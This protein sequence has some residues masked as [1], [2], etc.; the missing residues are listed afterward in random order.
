[1]NV[2]ETI[3][4]RKKKEVAEKKLTTGIDFFK[5]FSKDFERKCISLKDKLVSGTSSG[6]IAEFKRKSPSKGWI[7]ESAKISEIVPFY[8]SGGAVA[9]S[10][11]TD[12]E[13][14]GGDIE[15][16]RTARNLVDIPLLRKDFIVD[17]FQ[18][19]EAKSYGADLILLIAAC[20]SAEEVKELAKRAKDLQLEIL[21]ELH[22]EN[23]M[24]HIC[25]EI[26][27]IGIN[28]RNLDT[29]ETDVI[30]SVRMIE[31]MPA[32]KPVISESGI[33]DVNTILSLKNLGFQGFLIGEAFMK[34]KD[35][36][37]AFA[38]FMKFLST[39]SKN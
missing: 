16:L 9:I 3:I 31:L 19:Y 35:P 23:E 14:F 24:G 39:G 33:N 2:L 29:F 15:E 11:L 12:T 5:S 18:L 10:I 25:D 17:E 28:N 22:S 32:H 1:M 13:F 38:D 4:A 34:E 6:I 20:L 26:D 7:N 21:L 37:I 27:I 8:A 36:A 30:T